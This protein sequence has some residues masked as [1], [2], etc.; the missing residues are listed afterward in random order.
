MSTIEI[1]QRWNGGKDE[2]EVKP[3][4]ERFDST[5][6][7]VAPIDEHYA[8]AFVVQHHYS[9]SFPSA[10]FSYGLFDRSS[11]LVGVFVG[12]HPT[13]DK[14]I[15]NPLPVPKATDGIDLGR[16]V[17]RDGVKFYAETWFLA[18]CFELLRREG[19]AGVV[20]FSD[21]EKRTSKT[22]DLVFAGHWG[23]IYQAHNATYLGKT[24]AATIRLLPNGQ[25]ISNRAIQ[26]VRS[27]ERG[28]RYVVMQLVDAGYRAP[29]IPEME[30]KVRR[31]DW[32]HA[33]L[34]MVTRT[35][36]HRGNHRYA[37]GLAKSVKKALSARPSLPYPKDPEWLAKQ[38]A[39]RRS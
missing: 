5:H 14:V 27:K 34:A 3:R 4:E 2:Y 26:K 21:P 28:W 6:Y 13:N 30:N 12:S 9:G 7:D 39:R 33:A 23:L 38:A 15:T 31:L 18:R 20:S 19:I 17:L 10:R 25:V 24:N 29:S 8:R 16:F 36:R 32:L 1:S 11:E 35:M 22:G 37:W